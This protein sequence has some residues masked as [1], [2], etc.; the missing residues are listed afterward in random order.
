MDASINLAWNEIR[1]RAKLVKEYG[2]V[3]FV[4]GTEA[5]LGQVFLNMLVNA[6]H[7]LEV[8]DSAQNVIRVRAAT[9]GEGQVVVQVS[10][11]GPGIPPEILDR[12]FDPFFTTKPVGGTGLG[13]W[14]CQGIVTSLGGQITAESRPGEGA[15]FRVVLPAA[16]PTEMPSQPAL[17]REVP[18]A[19]S[20]ARLSLLVVDDE[21]AIGRTLAASRSATSSTW[22]PPRAEREALV[23]LGGERRFDVVLCDLMMPDVSGMDVYESVA[24]L[25]PELAQRFVF[26]TGGAFTERARR[27]V[28]EVGLPVVEKPFDLEEAPLPSC[29]SGR[30]LAAREAAV[31]GAL[32][33][34]GR[35]WTLIVAP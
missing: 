27:F 3:P 9:E 23:L 1:H 6:A 7:A 5:R 22:R 32:L 33:E 15:T 34:R 13:L 10:D 12:I 11:T 18:V 8:G 28:E 4:L 16:S 35:H 19:E 17:P 29:G 14:I 25:R 26:V 24:E 30:L 21:S 20:A 2:D 31:D